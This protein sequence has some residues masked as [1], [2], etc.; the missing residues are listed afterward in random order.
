MEEVAGNAVTDLK[1]LLGS[2]RA[3]LNDNAGDLVAD[4]ERNLPAKNILNQ[5]W[6]RTADRAVSDLYSYILVT[7]RLERNITNLDLASGLGIGISEAADFNNMDAL[8]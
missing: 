7:Q 2:F 6:V 5:M 3:K 1:P 8:H 4:A